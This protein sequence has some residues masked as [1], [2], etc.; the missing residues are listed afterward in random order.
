MLGQWLISEA[1]WEKTHHR[2]M[3][4]EP[5]LTW[6]S[7]AGGTPRWVR[8]A[9]QSCPVGG[10]ASEVRALAQALPPTVMSG[11]TARVAAVEAVRAVSLPAQ[12]AGS[13][14]RA[15]AAGQAS[16]TRV[17]RGKQSAKCHAQAKHIQHRAW[18]VRDELVVDT[19]RPTTTSSRASQQDWMQ[20]VSQRRVTEIPERFLK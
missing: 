7:E 6:R 8:E 18:A 11:P 4:S 9:W 16:V 19:V 13:L 20:Y 2:V 5:E 15:R 12:T 17:H 3:L 1:T 10:N 14:K